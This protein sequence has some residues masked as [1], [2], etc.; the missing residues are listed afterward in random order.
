MTRGH[1]RRGF[2]SALQGTR[3]EDIMGGSNVTMAKV[4]PNI[5]LSDICPISCESWYVSGV[6]SGYCYSMMQVLL[7][8]QLMPSGL[9]SAACYSTASGLEVAVCVL[10]APFGTGFSTV[11]PQFN[12][13]WHRE[14]RYFS[15][16]ASSHLFREPLV[17]LA[18]DVTGG[19]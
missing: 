8:I 14:M 3:F 16:N 19:P 17:I 11:Y 6:L 5:T 7:S 15:Q 12:W 13:L 2:C 4:A 18:Y 10:S 1:A 9:F